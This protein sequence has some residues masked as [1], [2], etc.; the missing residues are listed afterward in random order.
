MNMER[1]LI[2]LRI[3]SSCSLVFSL[4]IRTIPPQGSPPMQ[5]LRPSS[6]FDSETSTIYIIGGS[7]GE[8]GQDS[9]DIYA[10][11]LITNQWSYVY[12]ESQFIPVGM[13][14]HFSYLASNRVIYTFGVAEKLYI[15]NVYTF[16]LKTYQWGTTNIEGD[17]IAGRKF[18]TATS[19]EWNNEPYIAIYGGT[20][21]FGFDANLYL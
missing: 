15:S 19:F 8:T 14:N 18:P 1:L 9:S 4:D 11:S 7:N 17:F 20:C 6:V 16:D 5:I 12:P 13:V 2:L 3:L 10:F 21:S